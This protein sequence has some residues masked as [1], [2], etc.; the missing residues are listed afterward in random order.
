MTFLFTTR[1]K[2]IA[3]ISVAVIISTLFLLGYEL[4]WRSA[5]SECVKQQKTISAKPV[6]SSSER[7]NTLESKN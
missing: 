4:G 6:S 7:T 3:I 5:F 1:L 2:I